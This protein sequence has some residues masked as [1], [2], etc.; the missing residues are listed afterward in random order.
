MRVYA[1]SS[2][3]GSVT[4]PKLRLNNK[5]ET[6]ENEMTVSSCMKR[7]GFALVALKSIAFITALSL[8][9]SH[10]KKQVFAD[11]DRE[12]PATMPTKFLPLILHLFLGIRFVTSFTHGAFPF[13]PDFRVFLFLNVDSSA[14]E[15]L[16]GAS[17]QDSA[18]QD[19]RLQTCGCNS[20]PTDRLLSSSFV[21]HLKVEGRCF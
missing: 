1:L 2:F 4:I 8:V 18:R 3:T 11:S 14:Q 17:F 10:W 5:V 15:L 12:M 20:N 19:V 7:K 21:L 16:H 9:H 6:T 13:S